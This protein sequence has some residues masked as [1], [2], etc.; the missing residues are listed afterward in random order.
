MKK[1]PTITCKDKERRGMNTLQFLG[2]KIVPDVRKE[3]N[4]A[5]KLVAV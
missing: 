1:F 4:E 3:E 2:S 5:L